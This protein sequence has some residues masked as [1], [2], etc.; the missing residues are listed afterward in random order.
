M[1]KEGRPIFL[2]I[3]VIV[4]LILIANISV[5]MYKYGNFSNGLT[6]FSVGDSLTSAY[7]DLSQTTK[8]FLAAQWG[9]LVLIMIFGIIRDSVVRSRMREFLGNDLKKISEKSGTDLDALYSLLQTRKQLRV[10]TISKM[11][12]I[13]NDI[14][15]D[16][17][18]IL[19]TGNLA[20]IDYK[21]GEPI[22]KV[23]EKI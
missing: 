8:I 15:M 13:S 1:I 2:K 6:G 23:N 18:K 12:N 16:W 9:F 10:S 14:A 7:S 22:I 17:C 4:V 19:E 5:F 20:A 3:S 21:M 11:F